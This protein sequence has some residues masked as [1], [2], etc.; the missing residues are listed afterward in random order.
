MKTN[1]NIQEL[2]LKNLKDFLIKNNNDFDM[3]KNKGWDIRNI[4]L[5]LK[6]TTN[7]SIGYYDKSELLGFVVGDK[8]PNDINFDIEIYLFYVERN[9]RRKNIGTE[10]LNFINK[11]K[12]QLNIKKIFLEVSELNQNAINF[13]EKNGFVL[14]K[15]RHNYYR[16]KNLNI[17]AKCYYKIL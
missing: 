11:Q 15:I 1:H 5:Q 13:Y 4:G 10:L 14:F 9:L 17:S 12:I 2:D 3:F 7:F 8:I 6:K 16:E